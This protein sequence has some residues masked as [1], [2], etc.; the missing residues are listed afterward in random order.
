MPFILDVC[1]AACLSSRREYA[2]SLTELAVPSVI[3]GNY[4]EI[5]ALYSNVHRASGVDADPTLRL[6][7]L[8][9]AA[10]ELARKL[11]TVVLASGGTDIVTD[12]RR[13]THI[14][15]GTPQLSTITG[16]GC[17]QGALCAA[18][19][20]AADAFSAAVSACAVFGI[21]GQLAETD[22]GSGSFFIGLHDALS[23]VGASEVQ[24]YTDLEE[25]EIEEV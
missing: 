8:E 25:K 22:K 13:I 11:G 2:L 24:K 17:M 1:G 10:A 19:L 15:N 16:T 23:T 3:K 6:E 20:S 18:Y 9:L 4:S 14:K 7:A 12:G 5:M 21:C